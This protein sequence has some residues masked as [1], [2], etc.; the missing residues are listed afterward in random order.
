MAAAPVDVAVKLDP[1]A[2]PHEVAAAHGFE[3]IGQI[4]SLEHHYIFRHPDQ[5]LSVA[6]LRAH[7]EQLGRHVAVLW[8][9]VQVPKRRMRRDL[10]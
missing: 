3:F 6:A 10:L 9:E 1:A 8:H 7:A 4:G 5:T 2:N